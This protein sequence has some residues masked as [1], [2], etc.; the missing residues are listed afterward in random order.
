M[1][2][3][4]E[5][6]GFGLTAQ[7]QADSRVAAAGG[8]PERDILFTGDFNIGALKQRHVNAKRVEVWG[9]DILEASEKVFRD[10]GTR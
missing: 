5:V 8:L 2:Q 6:V 9:K 4:A 10:N 3:R 1:A 7:G